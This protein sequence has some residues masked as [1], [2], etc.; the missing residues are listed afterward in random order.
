MKTKTRR[1]LSILITLAL[2]AGLFAATPVTAYAATHSVN[3]A[4][5]LEKA[6]NNFSSG[7]FIKLG[8]DIK[9][10]KTITV[11]GKTV[12]FILNGYNLEVDTKKKGSAV[13]Y[14]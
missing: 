10:D 12:T 7:D 6:L 8:A 3:D 4:E 13:E 9:Y 1:V 11:R 2:A 14:F 5:S